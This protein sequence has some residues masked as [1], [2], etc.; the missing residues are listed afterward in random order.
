MS[1]REPD[2]DIDQL[3]STVIRVAA[4]IE[5]AIDVL[6]DRLVKAISG[7]KS[8]HL[9]TKEDFEVLMQLSA[10]DR[11]KLA[12]ELCEGTSEQVTHR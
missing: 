10:D 7:L 8:P 3:D 4:N 11:V 9:F 1:Y 5:K 6:G 12:Q 2:P